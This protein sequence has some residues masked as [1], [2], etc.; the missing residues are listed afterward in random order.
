MMLLL[1]MQR[2]H[3]AME[4]DGRPGTC[5]LV[6]TSALTG[7]GVVEAFRHASELGLAVVRESVGGWFGSRSVVPTQLTVG[8]TDMIVGQATAVPRVR[9]SSLGP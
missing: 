9:V 6:L 5:R 4:E 7:E 2:I 1:S 3:G 8:L